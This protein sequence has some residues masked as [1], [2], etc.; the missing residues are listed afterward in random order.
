M[1]NIYTFAA[2]CSTNFSDMEVMEG[3][4]KKAG[5]ELTKEK[6]KADLFLLAGCNVKGPSENSF[7]RKLKSLKKYNKP[8]VI[9]GCIPQAFPEKFQEYSVVGTSQINNIAKVV[10]QTL[11][12]NTIKILEKEDNCLLNLPK[13]RKNKIIEIVP[14]CKGCLGN[15]NYCV[16]KLSRGN[17][18][19]Y[20]EETIIKHIKES[21]KQGI[22]EIWLTGQDTGCYGKDINSSLPKLLNKITKIDGDFKI[23]IGM[24]NP[25]HIKKFLPELIKEMKSEKVFKFLHLPIQS[26]NNEILK[27]M[28]RFYTK[29]DFLNI[30]KQ[31]KKEFPKITISTDIIVGYPGETEEQFNETLELIKELKSPSINISKFWARPKTKAFEEK[32]LDGLKIKERSKTLTK[33]FKEIALKENKKWINWEGE[34]VIDEKGKNN[35]FVARNFAYKP[36]ILKGDY[37]LGQKAKVKILNITEFDLRGF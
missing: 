15:C 23:R 33:I 21:L 5:F 3:L 34:V 12:Q 31:L 17:L 11:N 14:I 27:K 10:N 19:S 29:E 20:S 9:A 32:Q 2:G 35:T 4:L 22:K 30:I 6:E 25:N 7:F 1:V 8:F 37:I 16:V 28:N 24:A 36:I 26:G 18:I 13:V